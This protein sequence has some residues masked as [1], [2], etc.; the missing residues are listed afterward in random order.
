MKVPLS[1]IWLSCFLGRDVAVSCFFGRHIAMSCFF[2]RDVAMSC[3]FSRNMAMSCFFGRDMAV[4]CFFWHGCG[5]VMFLW[6]GCGHVT[7]WVSI[8]T[9]E[10]TALIFGICPW[11][12][13]ADCLALKVNYDFDENCLNL[14]FLIWHLVDYSLCLSACFLFCWSVIKKILYLFLNSV[15]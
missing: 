2:D 4:S 13:Y 9:R 7:E 14:S 11:I 6:Q 12:P 5:Y 15:H 1:G 8:P 10:Q 3:F